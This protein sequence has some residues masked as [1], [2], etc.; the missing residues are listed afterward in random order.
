MMFLEWL[1]S[2]LTFPIN[3]FWTKYETYKET[4]NIP[5]LILLFS[6][7]LSGVLLLALAILKLADYLFTYH[8]NLL[9]VFGII[10]WLYTYIRDKRQEPEVDSTPTVQ[11]DI[12]VQAEKGY[13]I[14]RNVIFQT[15]K[16]TA[17]DIGGK[18]PR[19]LGEIEVSDCHFIITDNLCFYQ[20]RL[21][22]EDM[23][24]QYTEHDLNE[25]K[26][27][28]QTNLAHKIQSGEF[29]TLK[30]ENYRD[31]YGNW[32]D[33]IIIDTIEDIGNM[34]I[35]QTVFCSPEYAEYRHQIDISK[36]VLDGGKRNI[37]ESWN[38][39]P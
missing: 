32:Y 5:M 22:K 21:L 18:V 15:V 29:P 27:I 12:M 13:S 8:L 26:S 1:I 3:W 33:S 37:S 4:N 35:L 17:S 10:Y 11:T 7:S 23:M 34:F 31:K 19:L 16:S 25:F 30:M 14:M 9:I 28:F 39:T 38:D 20:F 36:D 24:V 6:F 2:L